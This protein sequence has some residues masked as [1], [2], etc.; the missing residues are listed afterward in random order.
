MTRTQAGEDIKTEK[1]I[2]TIS[3][4]DE[5]GKGSAMNSTNSIFLDTDLQVLALMILILF[6][7]QLPLFFSRI[8]D[9]NYSHV[10]DRDE[11]SLFSAL[12]PLL[13]WNTHSFILI[14][15]LLSPSLSLL[16]HDL[17][18]LRV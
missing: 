15:V 16:I 13:S 11:P 1:E 8:H 14:F 17:T 12:H 5:E 2:L 10:T 9:E 3:C 4:H 6:L 7:E 18:N